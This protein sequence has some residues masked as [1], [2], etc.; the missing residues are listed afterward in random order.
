[1]GND[2]GSI[3]KR[4]ELVKEKQKEARPDQNAVLIATWFFCALSKRLLQDPVVA[5]RLGKLYNKDAVLEYLLNKQ[6]YGDGDK[7][8]SHINSLRDVKTLKVTPNPS[9]KKASGS[10]ANTEQS[11]TSRFICPISMKEMNG[12]VKF[13]YLD[14]CGCVFSEQGLK[15]VPNGTCVQCSKPY[16]P[17]DVRTIN[18]APEELERLKNELAEKTRSKGKKKQKKADKGKA[19]S[20]EEEARATNGVGSNGSSDDSTSAEASSS[21]VTK[22]KLAEDEAAV[23]PTQSKKPAVEQQ[24]FARGAA[25]VN[26]ST[27][28]VVHKRVQEQLANSASK[29]KQSKAIRSIYAKKDEDEVGQSY[30]VR[31]TFNRYA[32]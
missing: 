27:A 15:Q 8:C 20:D 5:C 13:V 4:N 2:G 31:G 17:E 30:L 11:M 7:I 25:S 29:A 14:T 23:S 10:A 1:M 6:A 19:K 28:A 12:K 32:A 3:P 18:P 21:K 16:K 22:R 26:S 9:F 24:S